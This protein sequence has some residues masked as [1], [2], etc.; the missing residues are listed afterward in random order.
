MNPAWTMY[1]GIYIAE[2]SEVCWDRQLPNGIPLDG[3]TCKKT[4]DSDGDLLFV[5]FFH[6]G[7]MVARVYND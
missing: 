2:A 4:Y 7:K 5:E 3:K 1:E 6:R